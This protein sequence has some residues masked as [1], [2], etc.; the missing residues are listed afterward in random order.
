MNKDELGSGEARMVKALLEYTIKQIAKAKQSN[1][2][3]IKRIEKLESN[4]QLYEKQLD[5]LEK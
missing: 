5:D 1:D 2:Q 4:K 3:D